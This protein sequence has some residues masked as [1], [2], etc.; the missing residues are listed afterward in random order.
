M[1]TIGFKPSF[2]MKEKRYEDFESRGLPEVV[3]RG[4]VEDRNKVEATPTRLPVHGHKPSIVTEED[5]NEDN[6]LEKPTIV[7]A[8]ELHGLPS[9]YSQEEGCNEIFRMTEL[10]DH[11]GVEEFLSERGHEVEITPKI[12]CSPIHYS[13]LNVANWEN[14]K[15][16]SLLIVAVKVDCKM[17]E[18][19]LKFG[20]NPNFTNM[21]R[22]S[23][24]SI[25][26]TR[27]DKT[28]IG[29]LLMAGANLEAAVVKLTSSLRFVSEKEMQD[30][31]GIGFSVRPLVVLLEGDVYL[32][33][34]D[35]IKTAFRVDKG[36]KKI[37]QVRD[38]FRAEF[39]MLIQ[40]VD[41][42]AWEF[43]DH[44]DKISEAKEILTHPVD[45]VRIATDQ[46][47]KRFV[48]H[49]FSQQV[50]N[51][52]WNGDLNNTLFLGKTFILL[53]YITS[54]IV[55]PLLFIK[56]LLF[57]FRKGVPLMKSSFADLLTLT[58]TPYLCFLTDALNY[59]ATLSVVIYIC[60]TPSDYNIGTTE[61]VLYFCVFS[62]IL[63]EI[64]S[65]VQEGW[66]TYFQDF[67]NIID[68]L[69]ILLLSVAAVYEVT[70]HYQIDGING[71][72]SEKSY[73][74][75]EEDIMQTHLDSMRVSYMYAV[76][77]FILTLRIL[78]FLE[79]SKSLGTMLIAL[80]CLIRDVLKFAVIFLAIILGT[81]IAIYSMTITVH[82][83][84]KELKEAAELFLDDYSF[85]LLPYNR[86][87]TGESVRVPAVFRT[88]IDTL[89]N[90]MWSTFGLLNVV[91]SDCVCTSVRY[92]Y[93]CHRSTLLL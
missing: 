67:W 37:M 28:T 89:R 85:T 68:I 59:L 73:Q 83:W 7:D 57:E 64:D 1:Q 27:Y 65:L 10:G 86:S 25:A 15:G 76:A 77:E 56:Y 16:D 18:I 11:S 72:W 60:I 62:R 69:A 39:E 48:S 61:C 34:R 32:K 88:F 93:L 6:T 23:P 13:K 58:L 5:Q 49:P 26:A 79:I 9:T 66:K 84:N 8:V 74:Q 47:K 45:L 19:V 40:E 44:C 24:L 22:D 80:K 54:P 29:V 75:L 4:G 52:S 12:G 31:S 3:L 82:E 70:I 92:I 30:D 81:A 55:L 50:I 20:G 33:C 87:H 35:P 46:E 42:F 21:D 36:I 17:V 78:G 41:T 51:E 71:K 38:E 90:T 2:Q 63:N 43:L 14:K 53:R 91:V